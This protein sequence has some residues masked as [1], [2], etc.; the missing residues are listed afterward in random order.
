MY[1]LDMQWLPPTVEVAWL[2]DLDDPQRNVDL[3]TVLGRDISVGQRAP[4]IR[5]WR[6]AHAPGIG[7]SRKDVAGAVGQAAMAKLQAAGLAVVVRETGGTAV[8]QG[9]GVLHLSYIVPRPQGRATTDAFYRLLCGPIIE[10][11][12]RLGLDAYTGALPGSYCDG[13][14]NVLVGGRKLVG[15]AQAWR[16]GL[17]GLASR[18]PGYILAHACITVTFDMVWAADQINRFYTWAGQAYRVDPDLAVSLCDLVPGRW[19]GLSAADAAAGAGESLRQTL[20]DV[21]GRAGIEVIAG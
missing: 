14:Y 4:L 21:F 18:H 1:E 7:V 16:G 17:A 8:P 3:D 9:D 11:L 19:A 15:T 13:S 10:W 12:R 6:A 2:E 20:C 5:M